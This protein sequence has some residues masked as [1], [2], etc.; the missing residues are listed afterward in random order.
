MFPAP[1]S[2]LQGELESYRHSDPVSP[3]YLQLAKAQAD[4]QRLTRIA[5]NL[6]TRVQIL[7]ANTGVQ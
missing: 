2:A 3:S 7:E 1:L 4:I 6:T 5:E